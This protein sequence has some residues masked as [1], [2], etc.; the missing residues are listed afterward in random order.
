MIYASKDFGLLLRVKLSTGQFQ[1]KMSTVQTFQIGHD[2]ALKKDFEK[3]RSTCFTK[4][5]LTVLLR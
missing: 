1:S 2:L 5:K 3:C 4:R